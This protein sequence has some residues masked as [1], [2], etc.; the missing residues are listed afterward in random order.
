MKIREELN[1][2]LKNLQALKEQ[3]ERDKFG[4]E[5]YD[6]V[7]SNKLAENPVINEDGK[8]YPQGAFNRL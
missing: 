1:K 3:D 5:Q 8:I 2:D 4:D 7:H 6:L